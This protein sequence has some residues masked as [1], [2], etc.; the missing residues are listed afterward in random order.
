MRIFG[1]GA[2]AAGAAGTSGTVADYGD[3][4]GYGLAGGVG[5]DDGN[6]V[7]A[8]LQRHVG[9]DEVVAAD[10]G[11]N[12]VDQYAG[13]GA[14]DIEYGAF[15]GC[16]GAGDDGAV[17][18]GYRG[19]LRSAAYR[20][21][22]GGAGIPA[23]A[24]AT[25]GLQ[26]LVVGLRLLVTRTALTTLTT[27]AILVVLV[28]LRVVAG[29]ALA[30]KHVCAIVVAGVGHDMRRCAI[31]RPLVRRV[32]AKQHLIDGG[33]GDAADVT[34]A[35]KAA[36]FTEQLVRSSEGGG[37]G[38]DC[39]GACDRFCNPVRYGYFLHGIQLGRNGCQDFQLIAVKVRRVGDPFVVGGDEPVVGD[40]EFAVIYLAGLHFRQGD[41]RWFDDDDCGRN[42]GVEGLGDADLVLVLDRCRGYRPF[43][44]DEVHF[45]RYGYDGP[46][47]GGDDE[48]RRCRGCARRR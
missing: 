22:D 7:D 36:Y 30:N 17:K 15:D 16:G 35:A 33:D 45:E 26:V 27:L 48:G 14:A 31:S 2:S 10:R 47:P 29:G 46:E 34:A 13:Q 18:G 28:I 6:G 1:E 9:G 37:A 21:K 41:R 38:S 23:T 5:D 19:H 11:G 32:R 4:G 8:R 20:G 40:G 12:A 3:G 39:G 44:G 24:A 42:V 43:D 25:L